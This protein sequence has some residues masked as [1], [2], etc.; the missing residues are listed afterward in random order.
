MVQLGGLVWV[1]SGLPQV[2]IYCIYIVSFSEDMSSCPQC[3]AD[4][5]KSK[6]NGS[7]LGF[8]LLLLEHGR[9]REITRLS[10]S[11][12]FNFTRALY[13]FST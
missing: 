4:F 8:Y 3:N 7:I 10:A 1:V 5:H 13:N 9:G 12:Q 2:T 6:I 11:K